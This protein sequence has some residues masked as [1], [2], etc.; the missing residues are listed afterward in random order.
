MKKINE[1][2][3]MVQDYVRDHESENITAN[4]IAEALDLGSKQVNG[5]ITMTFCRHKEEIDGEK[6]EVPLME[7]V[8][9][10]VGVDE[11]GK[12]KVPKYIHLTEA[13]K[14]IELEVG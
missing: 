7:R 6:V 8:P 3:K 11:K 10:E 4:D 13:G 2:G 14:E 9:G 1:S 12:P 5:I